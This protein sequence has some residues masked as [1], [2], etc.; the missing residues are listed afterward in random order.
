[1]RR[2]R[3]RVLKLRIIKLLDWFDDRIIG[4]RF[5]WLCHRIGTSDWWGDGWNETMT[6]ADIEQLAKKHEADEDL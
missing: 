3:V 4:H 2:D 5:Y 1:M 6:A